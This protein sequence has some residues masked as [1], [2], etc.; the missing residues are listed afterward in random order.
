M[1]GPEQDVDGRGSRG[2]AGIR[3][4]GDMACDHRG[5]YGGPPPGPDP[6]MLPVNNHDVPVL[7]CHT[8]S[9]CGRMRSA[10]FH[11]HN[12]VVPG[13][14]LVSSACRKCK[15]KMSN[16]HQP[17]G[18]SYTRVKS[19]D[20]DGRCIHVNIEEGHR[21]GR[22][23]D[24]DEQV[25][26]RRYSPSPPT[27]LIRR[28]SSQ[29]KLGLRVF[30]QDYDA[31]GVRKGSRILR[32]SS[33]SPP[34][35]SRYRDIWPEPDVV[36][37]RSTTYKGNRNDTDKDDIWPPPD[38]VP[39]RSYKRITTEVPQLESRIVELS[40]SLL[41][42]LR[43]RSTRAK[44]RSDSFEARPRG[45][46]TGPSNAHRDGPSERAEER[47]S[48]HPRPY[49]QVV[50]IYAERE[51]REEDEMRGRLPQRDRSMSRG[52]IRRYSDEE[53]TV[54]KRKVTVRDEHFSDGVKRS[55]TPHVRFEEVDPARDDPTFEQGHE[56]RYAEP[57]R[58]PPGGDYDYAY[59]YDRIDTDPRRRDASLR[60]SSPPVESMRRFRIHERSSYSPPHS[61]GFDGPRG[62]KVDRI[63]ASSFSPARGPSPPPDIEPES[64]PMRRSAETVRV[65]YVS[66]RRAYSYNLPPPTGPRIARS[67]SPPDPP[68]RASRRTTVH[69]ESEDLRKDDDDGTSSS[70]SYEPMPKR[71]HARYHPSIDDRKTAR[72]SIE[73]R[74]S[75]D[76]DEDVLVQ[77]R[78]WKGIDEKGRKATFVEEKRV[79]SPG[80]GGDRDGDREVR[81]R[82][83]WRDV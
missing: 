15:K 38:T 76:D 67:L 56:P 73:E 17:S 40:L 57:P 34:R 66:P 65:R 21:R 58:G 78:K 23:R 81:E 63:R 55:R 18:G 51:V 45:R 27:H 2:P 19:C 33:L 79:Y 46:S 74:R 11:R 25:V 64:I 44:Y 42:P 35:A 5:P 20:R 80:R 41:L 49:R 31:F 60:Q 48:S 28:S 24:R 6:A 1:S 37:M 71:S 4:G 50:P 7:L 29:A 68:T 22:R 77:V 43:A 69:V 62:I 16:G 8:C 10:G 3:G 82:R 13:K 53:K 54:Y 32:T 47:L 70:G 36:R 9:V 52:A 14:P 26:Y 83:S 39:L 59:R 12:P 30:Q 61:P 75:R 72:R